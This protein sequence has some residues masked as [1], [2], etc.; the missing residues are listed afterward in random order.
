MPKVDSDSDE[1]TDDHG[2]SMRIGK[3]RIKCN[4]QTLQIMF[5]KD[6][7]WIIVKEY[8]APK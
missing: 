6:G 3:W 4:E 8:K 1:E 5:M 7:E 2:P